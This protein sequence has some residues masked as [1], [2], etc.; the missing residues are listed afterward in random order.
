MFER[1]VTYFFGKQLS[2]KVACVDL[3]NC[4]IF[5]KVDSIR[6]PTDA[7]YPSDQIIKLIE[8]KEMREHHCEVINVTIIN[9]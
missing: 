9:M 7:I 5:S 2:Y 3:Y 6:I 4:E 1:L 8:E